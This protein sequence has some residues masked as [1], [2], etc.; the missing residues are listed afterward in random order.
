MS[1]APSEGSFME[2]G[3]IG[4]IWEVSVLSPEEDSVLMKTGLT[5]A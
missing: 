2:A 3:E 4:L 5:L 1:Q